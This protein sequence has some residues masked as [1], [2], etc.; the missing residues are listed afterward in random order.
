[1]TKRVAQFVLLESFAEAFGGGRFEN[2]CKTLVGDFSERDLSAMVET[3]GDDAAIVQNRNMRVEG[4]AS[5]CCVSLV[6][7]LLSLV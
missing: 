2:F 6:S 7:R 3:A 5:P 1:M 4:A